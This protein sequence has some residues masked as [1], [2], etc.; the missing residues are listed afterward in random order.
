M[1][2]LTQW[3]YCD[4]SYS[5]SLS[6]AIAV[7]LHRSLSPQPNRPAILIASRATHLLCHCTTPHFY[8]TTAIYLFLILFLTFD[9][10][11]L[12]LSSLSLS[13][14]PPPPSLA[15][16]AMGRTA[17]HWFRKGLRLHD[18]P[19]L[20]AAA[21]DNVNK[22]YCVFVLDPHFAKPSY[23]GPIKYNFL[24]EVRGCVVGEGERQ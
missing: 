1:Y 10:L 14:P 21:A 22:L 18:N 3:K 6:F 7:S 16:N 11:S 20:L 4:R 13:P 17:L 2:E 12:T 24:L 5:V 9:L 19:A 15:F 8:P 23:I